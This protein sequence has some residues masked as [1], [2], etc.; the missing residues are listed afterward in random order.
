MKPLPSDDELVALVDRSIHSTLPLDTL[1]MDRLFNGRRDMLCG[2]W[3]PEHR[4]AYFRAVRIWKARKRVVGAPT[5]TTRWPDP[6]S[7]EAA[8]A[9]VLASSVSEGA[10]WL[11]PNLTWLE[12]GKRLETPPRV[13]SYHLSQVQGWQFRGLASSRIV[14]MAPCSRCYTPALARS[15]ENRRCPKCR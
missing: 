9:A 15:V 1:L 7:V 13:A 3:C 11:V 2:D 8:W 6:P 12:I 14:L 5:V 4:A 10:W